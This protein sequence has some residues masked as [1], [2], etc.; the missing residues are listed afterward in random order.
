VIRLTVPSIGQE[1]LVAVREVLES[2]YLVQGK[3]VAAF[4]KAVAQHVGAPEAV[5]VSNCT[6]ALHMAL[7]AL[8][9]GPGDIVVVR[10]FYQWQL[11]VTGFGYNISNLVGNQ[12][13]LVAT[14]AFKNEP[15]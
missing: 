14:A 10:M 4:E 13:L 5:A 3:H 1:D 15:F 9:V 11:F 8:N 2:G 12:R 6:A 7:L